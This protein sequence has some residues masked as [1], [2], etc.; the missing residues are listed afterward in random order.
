MQY[1]SIPFVE[2]ALERRWYAYMVLVVREDTSRH[3]PWWISNEFARYS[4][5]DRM[6]DSTPLRK[7]RQDI[8]EC[9]RIH[10]RGWSSTRIW[11]NVDSNMR[12]FTIALEPNR[13]RRND[14]DFSVGKGRSSARNMKN[15]RGKLLSIFATRRARW[16]AH[17]TVDRAWHEWA[18]AERASH[19]GRVT[20]NRP[21]CFV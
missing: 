17:R 8:A 19:L 18:G 12:Y 11:S 5:K 1:D 15:D 20:L 4:I 16:S 10:S 13:S 3:D 14:S 7:I 9:N 21:T 2:F 6:L